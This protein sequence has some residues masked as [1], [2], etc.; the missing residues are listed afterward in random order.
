MR[1]KVFNSHAVIGYSGNM[2]LVMD[3]NT[4]AL[5]RKDICRM[6][7]LNKNTGEEITRFYLERNSIKNLE[8]IFKEVK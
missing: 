5:R 7:L 2:I 8:D 4:D 1:D 6:R 3:Y